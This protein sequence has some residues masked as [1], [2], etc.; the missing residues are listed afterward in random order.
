MAIINTY[1]DALSLAS[2][3]KKFVISSTEDIRFKLYCGETLIIDESYSPASD[4]KITIDVKEVVKN[5]LS[6][7]IPTTDIFLQTGIFKEFIAH[8]DLETKTFLA[9]RAGVENLAVS[10]TE[11]LTQ[12]FLTWQPQSKQ[13]GYSQ[14]EWLTYYAPVAGN[15][16]VK[17]YLTDTTSSVQTLAALAAGSCTS[18]NMMFSRIMAL[19][20]GEK[21]GYFD[22]WF[23][24]AA[25]ERLTYVQRYIY[26]ETE[27]IDE[28][29]LFENSLGGI[30]TA[31][32][33]GE[34]I[35]APE[36]TH[37]EGVYEEES[38]QLDDAVSRLFQKSTGWKSKVEA[39]WLWDFFRAIRK[40]KV[41]SGVIRKI[42]LKE[43]EVTDSSAEDMKSF[44]FTYRIASDKGLLNIPRSADPLPSNLEITT[45]EGLFFLAPRLVEFQNYSEDAG[46]IP[47][48]SPYIQSWFKISIAQLKDKI[49]P[50]VID[51]LTTDSGTMALSARQGMVLKALIDGLGSGGPYTTPAEVAAAISNIVG[52]SPEALN[53]LNELATALGNDPNFATTIINLLAGKEPTLPIPLEDDYLLSGKKTGAKAWVAPYSHPDYSA[54]DGI[55]GTIGHI[56]G[57][58]KTF[59]QMLKEVL[60][61]D[62]ENDA[63]CTS[64]NF[65]SQKSVSALGADMDKINFLSF[66]INEN[67]ELI[68]SAASGIDDFTFE[69]DENK[70]LILK[71]L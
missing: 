15:L 55:G 38:E 67:M 34:S 50:I 7:I 44:S 62:E 70:C 24:N 37:T 20:A 18:V 65:Y 43:S 33:S 10:A 12:N 22:V 25:A 5:E 1:P 63:L 3:L 68:M 69:I 64:K 23:E 39:A 53:T 51:G 66:T 30:D 29:F 48:Q 35:F 2:N 28:H 31:V 13:V 40:Y 54:E 27:T 46:L 19:Q 4:G 71:T 14:P 59:L 61:F 42:T 8:I 26:D 11:F 16:K 41:D 60:V 57:T 6:F 21:Y 45:P 47:I 9:I 32:M 36:I 49:K 17:F 58:D 56:K 52:S